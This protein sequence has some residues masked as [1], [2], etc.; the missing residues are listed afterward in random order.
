MNI[1]VVGWHN[2]L[3]VNHVLKGQPPPELSEETN[4]GWE[5]VYAVVGIA[6][7]GGPKFPEE[8]QLL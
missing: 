6:G 8:F 7:S 3:L 4:V 2:R 5:P 1:L